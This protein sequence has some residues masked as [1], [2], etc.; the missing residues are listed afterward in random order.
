MINSVKFTRVSDDCLLL[1]LTAA[2]S[3]VF[4]CLNQFLSFENFTEDDMTSI[5]PGSLNK[6][7]EKLGSI[8]VGPSVSHREKVAS[9]VL[10]LE[11]LVIEA[12]TVDALAASAISESEITTLS[13]E[14]GDNSVESRALEVKS[15]ACVAH[16]LLSCAESSEVLGCLGNGVSEETED[17]SAG[18]LSI[19][20]DVEE[21]LVS[22]LVDSV[23]L[24][25][26]SGGYQE[27]H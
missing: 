24:S 19:D 22:D 3:D 18:I 5:E 4:K 20:V 16:S 9:G 15:L 2:R 1:G 7:D 8:G 6:G 14:A 10:Q 11:I 23:C 12:G 26:G 21:D 13:H 25:Q 17:D 27:A